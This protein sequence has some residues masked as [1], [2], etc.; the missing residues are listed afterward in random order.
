MFMMLFKVLL[1]ILYSAVLNITLATILM[2]YVFKETFE[3]FNWVI[4]RAAEQIYLNVRGL[5][6]VFCPNSLRD[7]SQTVSAAVILL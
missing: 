6:L 2:G 1:V 5:F 3:R 7:S 4:L